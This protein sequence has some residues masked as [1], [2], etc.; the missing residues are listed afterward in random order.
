MSVRTTLF[1]VRV[2]TCAVVWK[3][4]DCYGCFETEVCT[5]CILQNEIKSV[6]FYVQ[7]C[8]YDHDVLQPCCIVCTRPG[9]WQSVC[10][11]LTRDL[12]QPSGDDDQEVIETRSVAY[13]LKMLSQELYSMQRQ[14]LD[15][16]LQN[17]LEDLV[18]KGRLQYWSKV[19]YFMP[20]L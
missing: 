12:Q 5:P 3:T 13:I 16:T 4:R 10:L 18:S 1:R 7:F 14:K 6:D 20:K 11:S 9:F 19:S 17:V 15:K 2:L 8:M